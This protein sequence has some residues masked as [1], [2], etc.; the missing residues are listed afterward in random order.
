MP[1]VNCST[2]EIREH[3]AAEELAIAAQ[4]KAQTGQHD[5]AQLVAALVA[6]IDEMAAAGALSA[7]RATAVKVRLETWAT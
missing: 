7:A 3:T 4:P 6:L 5:K 1:V 2:R